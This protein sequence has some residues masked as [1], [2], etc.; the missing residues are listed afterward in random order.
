LLHFS[1]LKIFRDPRKAPSSR[2][3]LE[4]NTNPK[5][6]AKEAWGIISRRDYNY[7]RSRIPEAQTLG[8]RGC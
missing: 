3:V 7:R 1:P 4:F 5:S 6:E 2:V 8:Q